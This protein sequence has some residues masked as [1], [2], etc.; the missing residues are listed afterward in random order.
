MRCRMLMV[1]AAA[2][3]ALTG[4]GGGPPPIPVAATGASAATTA[5]TETA[6]SEATST[7]VSADETATADVA[8][9]EATTDAATAEEQAPAS[10]Q[11]EPADVV[12]AFLEGAVAETGAADLRALVSSA[13][14]AQLDNG[15]PAGELLGVQSLPQGF[16]IAEV[17]P[18]GDGLMDVHATLQYEGG[19]V[20]RVFQLTY[21]E[22][23]Q[24]WV[25]TGIADPTTEVAAPLAAEAT[26]V[27]AEPNAA[28]AAAG[29][30]RPIAAEACEDLRAA[31][32]SKLSVEVIGTEALFNDGRALSGTSC[33]LVAKG[34]GTQ[35]KAVG[36]VA[37][38]L[39][40]LFTERGWTPDMSYAADG[41]TGTR[42]GFRNANS[43]ALASVGWTP[44]PDVS[45]EGPIADCTIPDEQQLFTVSVEVA[46]I[47]P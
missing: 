45:C 2:L 15:Q 40:A 26:A 13:Y 4:C 19:A 11:G 8:T 20:E 33:Q 23:T 24:Q 14:G 9:P 5:V 18:A 34:N 32:A 3:V 46:E 41:P 43:I 25:I 12:R 29:V 47:E 30:A 28:L 17:T 38:D 35:F 37:L 6:I 7:A 21:Q 42:I 27:A 1:A 31:V 10:D 16:T 22:D 39:G 44:T 36:D